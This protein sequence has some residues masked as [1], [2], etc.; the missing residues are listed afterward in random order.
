M[1]KL[2]FIIL[3]IIVTASFL[4]CGRG[5]GGG[6]SSSLPKGTV[7]KTQVV[8]NLGQ[9]KT[10][11][12]SGKLLRS[13]ASIPSAIQSITFTI[14]APDMA[15][16]VRV[17]TLAGRT[18]ISET[19]EIPSGSNRHFVIEALDANGNV[20]YR[21]DL[22]AD[23]TG[24]SADLTIAMVSVEGLAPVFSGIRDTGSIT[25]T[26]MVLTWDPATDNITP[27]ERI[28]YLIYI[29][30]TPGGQDFTNPNFVTDPGA[31]SFMITGLNPNTTYYIVVRAKDE[32]GNIDTN[33]TELPATTLLPPDTTAPVFEGIISAT[34]LS[35]TEISLLWNPATDDRTASADIVYLIYIST[36]SHGQN[37]SIPNFTTGRGITRYLI[38]GLSP[39]TTYCFIGRAKDGAGNIDANTVEK[40][41]KTQAPPPPPPPALLADLYPSSVIIN[42][43]DISF[44]LV[45]GGSVNATNVGAL[46]QYLDFS[47]IPINSCLT[48]ISVPA[49]GFV[50]QNVFTGFF[51]SDYKITV[52]PNNAVP[53]L[54][55]GNNAAC[56]GAY[57][58]FPPPLVACP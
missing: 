40:C 31:T 7:G 14:S 27:P 13:T 55:E 26:S 37:L 1:K 51:V 23:L 4:S 18:T 22:Y 24:A 57:C 44:D 16:I 6:S 38:S 5:G 33:T 19:F 42:A 34:A 15:T 52:D 25:T 47:A 28:Q 10:V 46:V 43:S 29:S 12:S 20:L 11:S 8:I 41:A 2:L 50:P 53:E 56:G 58:V 3:L 9:T 49:G 21:G 35:T 30:T 45:N 17:I 39:D 54:N 48:G 36:T 32:R